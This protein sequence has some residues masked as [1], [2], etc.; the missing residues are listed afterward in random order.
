[1]KEKRKVLRMLME[2]LGNAYWNATPKKRLMRM[3]LLL[4]EQ[5][6]KYGFLHEEII[7]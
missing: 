1:M 2:V 3:K 7:V 5:S 4:S 6:Y